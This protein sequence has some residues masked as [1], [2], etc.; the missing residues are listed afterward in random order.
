MFNKKY[1]YECHIHGIA[2]CVASCGCDNKSDNQ[3]TRFGIGSSRTRHNR[4]TYILLLCTGISRLPTTGRDSESNHT[5]H[6]N[7]GP[8]SGKRCRAPYMEDESG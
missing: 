5:M 6:P 7:R 3:D 2:R 8:A 4:K 1:K